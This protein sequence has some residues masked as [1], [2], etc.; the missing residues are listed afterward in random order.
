MF[1]ACI[2]QATVLVLP[3]L[4][5]L[6]FAFANPTNAQTNLS[7]V[8]VTTANQLVRFNSSRPNVMLGT[9]VT[10]TGDNDF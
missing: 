10:I 1:L 4:F 7:V 5:L 3:F 6:A 9:A 8:G 2:R